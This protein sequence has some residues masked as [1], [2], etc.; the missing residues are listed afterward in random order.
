MAKSMEGLTEKLEG[1]EDGLTKKFEGMEELV[2]KLVDKL[3]ATLVRIQRLEAAPPPPPLPPP[4][5]EARPTTAPPPPPH[6]WV[7]PLDLNA[8]PHQEAHPYASSMERPNGHRIDLQLRDA[9][10]AILGSHPP[11]TGNGTNT[12]ASS[13]FEHQFELCGSSSKSNPTPK[14]DFPKFTSEHPRLWIDKCEKYFEIYAV[15][16]SLKTTFTALNFEGPAA[17]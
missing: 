13:N 9:G 15:S 1:L 5:P 4:T 17:S 6:R 12:N 14:M 2:Q 8:A 10:G 11:H 3:D 16:K 7:N